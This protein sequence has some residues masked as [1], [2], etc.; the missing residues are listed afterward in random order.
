MVSDILMDYNFYVTSLESCQKPLYYNQVLI[1]SFQIV[2]VIPK[3]IIVA[4]SDGHDL[5]WPGIK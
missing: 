3:D 4:I 2:P 5:R 1:V